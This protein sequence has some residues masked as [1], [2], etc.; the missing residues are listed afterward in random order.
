MEMRAEIV[1]NP[2]R[3]GGSEVRYSAYCHF[4]S[5]SVAKYVLFLKFS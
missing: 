3:E 2:K 4:H 1:D 5:A